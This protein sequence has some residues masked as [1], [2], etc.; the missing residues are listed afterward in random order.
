MRTPCAAT[1]FSRAATLDSMV[2]VGVGAGV[3]GLQFDACARRSATRMRM[4]GMV[5]PTGS[6]FWL[7]HSRW[8]MTLLEPQPWARQTA[9]VARTMAS[10]CLAYHGSLPSPMFSHSK[11]YRRRLPSTAPAS[12][13]P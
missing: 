12:P 4:A 1:S 13:W 3:E 11:P 6:D 5:K 9:A 8:P 7:D 10:I 2:G